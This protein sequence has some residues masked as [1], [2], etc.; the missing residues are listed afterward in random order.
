MQIL[1]VQISRYLQLDK[2]VPSSSRLQ[3]FV[4]QLVNSSDLSIFR[5]MILIQSMQL[6][7]FLKVSLVNDL[8]ESSDEFDHSDLVEDS[9]LFGVR[10]I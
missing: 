4:T 9:L 2:C 3:Q 5:F 6:I 1:I 10:V 8:Q 7:A